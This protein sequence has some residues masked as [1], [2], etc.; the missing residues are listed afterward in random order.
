MHN[1]SDYG[2]QSIPCN[3]GTKVQFPTKEQME[4]WLKIMREYYPTMEEF[5]PYINQQDY[6][7]IY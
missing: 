2:G 3:C 6:I 1:I 5:N 7:V 4:A